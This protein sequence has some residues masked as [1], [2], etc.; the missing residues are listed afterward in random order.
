MAQV[1]LSL[2]DNAIDSIQHA[3]EHYTS[4]PIDERRYKFAI[5]HLCQGVNLLLKERLSREHP[6]FIYKDVAK[7][8]TTVDVRMAMTRLDKIAGVDLTHSR[9]IILELS[10]LRNRIEHYAVDMPKQQVDGTITR[11]V[12]FLVGFTRDELGKDFKT[13]IGQENW[14]ALLAIEGY[15]K[16]A[17]REAQNTIRA[18]GKD[19][20]YCPTCRADTATIT[21]HYPKDDDPWQLQR[22]VV[23]CLVCTSRLFTRTQ[24]RECK[25]EKCSE[26]PIVSHYSY[27]SDC[28]SRFRRQF[29]DLD[30]PLFFVEVR[31]WFH[32][33]ET[34]TVRQL[35][36]LL[37]NVSGAG[38]S[39]M[40]GHVHHLIDKGV[41]GF[42]NKNQEQVFLENR[43]GSSG[44]GDIEYHF[45]F[46]WVHNG[47]Q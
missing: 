5:L 15:F 8:G 17:V 21:D 46:E 7:Q 25:A 39:S 12:G 33:R 43:G 27:C 23:S 24:C 30:N 31:R 14:Q 6:H 13:Q 47:L 1:T 36:R 2:Y 45:E 34:I 18:Q 29:V 41:I 11:A 40:F 28:T 20:I 4:D 35:I 26:D 44:M 19:A 22:D 37:S 42:V 3:I 32:Q 10:A 16:N 9:D 38:P